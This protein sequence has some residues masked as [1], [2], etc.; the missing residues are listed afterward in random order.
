M[1]NTTELAFSKIFNDLNTGKFFPCRV[2]ERT[3]EESALRAKVIKILTTSP[4]KDEIGCQI[5]TAED[6]IFSD[7]NGMIFK[8]ERNGENSFDIITPKNNHFLVK[9]Y[10][11]IQWTD[12][13]DVIPD[14][15]L[16][17]NMLQSKL[18]GVTPIEPFTTSGSPMLTNRELIDYLQAIPAKWIYISPSFNE[19]KEFYKFDNGLTIMLKHTFLFNDWDYEVGEWFE[20]HSDIIDCTVMADELSKYFNYQ[21]HE[22][23]EVLL[24]KETS[25]RLTPMVTHNLTND[26]IMYLT[27][28]DYPYYPQEISKQVHN[29][30]YNG[31]SAGPETTEEAL[32]RFIKRIADFRP[33]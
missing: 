10:S 20:D 31:P 22:K 15:V 21:N 27:G 14:M 16:H 9:A 26:E 13:C 17:S 4:D 19:M 1:N 32:L 2:L 7:K 29:S 25:V 24:C 3:L 30:A 8:I 12:V 5:L 11:N 33:Q 28:M 18:I 6:K 23:E